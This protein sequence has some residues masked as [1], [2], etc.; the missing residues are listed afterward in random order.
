M[1]ITEGVNV[2]G[3]P[4]KDFPIGPRHHGHFIRAFTISSVKLRW[5]QSAGD[6]YRDQGVM[7]DTVQH[8]IA[9]GSPFIEFAAQTTIA[10]LICVETTRA[11]GVR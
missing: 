2:G 5:F 6:V 10:K 4:N 7:D 8:V 11:A 9:R 1:Y 3:V